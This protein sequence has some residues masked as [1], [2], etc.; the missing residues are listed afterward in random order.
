MKSKKYIFK[1]AKRYRDTS[2]SGGTETIVFLNFGSSLFHVNLSSF[3]ISERSVEPSSERLVKP[4][5]E[6]LVKPSSERL[7]KPNLETPVKP[8]SERE[9]K[10]N[11]ERLAEPT[12]V[13][14]LGHNL[15]D[16]GKCSEKP[17]YQ[18]F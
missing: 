1:V 5:S 4:S 12:K 16:S 2:N 6:R 7:V 15:V 11:S 9:V 18:S 17:R 14:S 10:P 3:P 13:A 8:N